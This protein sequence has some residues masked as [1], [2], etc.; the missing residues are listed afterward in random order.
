TLIAQD[1]KNVQTTNTYKSTNLPQN[2]KRFES[3][4]VNAITAVKVKENYYDKISLKE[5]NQ[6][7][8]LESHTPVNFDGNMLTNTDLIVLGNVLEHMNVTEVN[9]KNMI[10]M[11]NTPKAKSASALK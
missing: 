4:A 10:T 7:F 11:S 1:K 8:K 3:L 5:L 6:G 9:G 2:L